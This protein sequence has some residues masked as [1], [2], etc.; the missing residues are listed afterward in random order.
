MLAMYLEPLP[1][2]LYRGPRV[3]YSQSDI[4]T[5]LRDISSALV[6]LK[7][8]P[9]VHNDIKPRNITYSPRR[10]AVLIDFGLATTYNEVNAGGTPWY[11]PPDLLITSSRG[12]PGD[13]W[14]LGITMLYLLGKI[15]YPEKDPKQPGWA[16]LNLL[17]NEE[18][19]NQMKRWLQH[20]SSARAELIPVDRG[21][22]ISK[23]E[24]IVFNMVEVDRE[25][26]FNAEEIVSALE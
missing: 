10:G 8:I 3:K 16:L 2:S 21:T 12:S 25:L 17:H 6:Y 9:I 5:I 4:E 18:N 15:T 13:V 20:I 22:G 7:T 23:L 19:Q 11:L 14:A 1:T 26:R 24:S